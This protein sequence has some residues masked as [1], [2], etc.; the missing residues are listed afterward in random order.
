V[1]SDVTRKGFKNKRLE[2]TASIP[3]GRS[4]I[5]PVTSGHHPERSTRPIG[6]RHRDAAGETVAVIGM[7]TLAAVL[8]PRKVGE[9]ADDSKRL[10]KPLSAPTDD[11]AVVRQLTDPA[12]SFVGCKLSYK[13]RFL[14]EGEHPDRVIGAAAVGGPP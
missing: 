2:V 7:A 13:F 12:K 9:A 11:V 3:A 10:D 5:R 4:R 8:V 6:V 14:V 1:H